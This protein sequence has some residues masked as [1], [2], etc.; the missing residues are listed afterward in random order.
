M[1]FF[2][3]KLK[4]SRTRFNAFY[5]Y[6]R[7]RTK[8][9]YFPPTVFIEPTN[10]CN[11]KCLICPQSNGLNA[12][13]GFMD[14]NLFEEIL[15]QVKN[16]ARRIIFH[17]FGEPLLHPQLHQMIMSAKEYGLETSLHTN[18]SLLTEEKAVQILD[19]G[20][21]IL[22]FSFNGGE[23]K[24]DYER[25]SQVNVY[26]KVVQNIRTFLELKRLRGQKNPRVGFEVIKL[27]RPGCKFI[28]EGTFKSLFSGMHEKSFGG[29][30]A[31]HWA[32]DFKE[33]IKIGYTYPNFTYAPCQHLWNE[34]A[35]CWDGTV[36]GCCNDTFRTFVLGDAKREPIEKIWQCEKMYYLRQKLIDGEYKDLDLCKNCDRLFADKSEGNILKKLVKNVIYKTTI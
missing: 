17:L 22:V 14:F 20:L 23:N 5:G 25:I 27:F 3:Q 8:L 34:L 29:G 15:H 16:K 2:I 18:A 35:I 11:F 31:H 10:I 28:I 26:D 4:D 21:D 12:P 36:V 1:K 19:S 9:T 30:W 6:Y 33:T 32:G 13:Q 7:R 24:E